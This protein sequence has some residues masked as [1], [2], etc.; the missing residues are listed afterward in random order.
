LNR[1]ISLTSGAKLSIDPFNINPAPLSSGKELN[2]LVPVRIEGDGIV[3][4]ERFL[5]LKVRHQEEKFTKPVLLFVSDSPEK[6]VKDGIMFS[7]IL[8]GGS[9]ARLLYYHQNGS[10]KEK[11][12]IIEVFNPYKTACKIWFISGTGG[13]N[14]QEAFVGMCNIQVMKTVIIMLDSFLP[15]TEERVI[16]YIQKMAHKILQSFPSRLPESSFWNLQ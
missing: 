12:L 1:S 11:Y 9:P 2:L 8:S 13:P 6:I 4:I 14:T 15:Y 16:I 5:P 3:S 7:H 10:E